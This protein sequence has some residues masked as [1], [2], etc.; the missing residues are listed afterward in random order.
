MSRQVWLK[1]WT[2]LLFSR[3]LSRRGIWMTG[4]A[5]IWQS[6]RDCTATEPSFHTV[7]GAHYTMLG[8]EHVRSFQKILKAAL[9]ARR[10]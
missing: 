9:D 2:S 7:E 1:A 5:T 10:I 4:S 6:G 3:L 8:P